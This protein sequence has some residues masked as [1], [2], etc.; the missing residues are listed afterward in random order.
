[1]RTYAESEEIKIKEHGTFHMYVLQ[2][3][4]AVTNM[5]F[6]LNC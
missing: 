2:K 5:S 3:E 6:L 4:W 1:M